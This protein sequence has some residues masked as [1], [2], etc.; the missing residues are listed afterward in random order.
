MLN[1]TD[2]YKRIKTDPFNK[3][4]TKKYIVNILQKTDFKQLYLNDICYGA[5]SSLLLLVP[6]TVFLLISFCF[7]PFLIFS[8]SHYGYLAI[9]L[10]FVFSSNYFIF[11]N[12]IV[13]ISQFPRYRNFPSS[14]LISVCTV[15][16]RSA[17]H[18][19]TRPLYHR[20]KSHCFITR[21]LDALLRK[22]Y[23]VPWPITHLPVRES[24]PGQLYASSPSSVLPLNASLLFASGTTG[25]HY[26]L[27][28]PLY[29]YPASYKRPTDDFRSIAAY[30]ALS[31][32][33]AALCCRYTHRTTHHTRTH[34]SP[35]S[36]LGYPFNSTPRKLRHLAGTEY[37]HFR[38]IKGKCFRN[39]L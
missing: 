14:T 23:C 32:Y 35:V 10:S 12:F 8:Y 37:V 13:F 21:L 39:R 17:S 36:F 20:L 11:L 30:S 19:S 9:W 33:Y 7:C 3:V 5:Y 34:L 22:P 24:T 27:R 15:R 1:D 26:P 18:N 25:V 16:L 6:L 38:Y 4:Q 2:T 28:F 29:F 31:S